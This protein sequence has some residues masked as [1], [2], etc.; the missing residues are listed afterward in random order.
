MSHPYTSMDRS[1]FWRTAVAEK[2]PFDI[3]GLYR[4]KFSIS[5]DDKIAT[6]GSCFAQHIGHRLKGSGFRYVDP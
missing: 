5:P 1:A 2:S 4:K 6:A 3:A